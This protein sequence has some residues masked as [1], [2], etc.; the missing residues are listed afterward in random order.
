ME[1]LSTEG[2]SRDQAI[3]HL[4][5]SVDT[6]LFRIDNLLDERPTTDYTG[7]ALDLFLRNWITTFRKGLVE[8]VHE[9]RVL[10]GQDDGT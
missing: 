6:S 8:H 7:R 5:E 9:Y 4:M 1:L 10:L 2:M 3:L